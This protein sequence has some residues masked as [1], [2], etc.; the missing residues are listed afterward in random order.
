MDITQGVH[1]SLSDEDIRHI[2]GDNYKN[3]QYSELA[4]YSSLDGLLP[5]LLDYDII[6]YEKSIS[7][8]H[9]V[10]VLRYHNLFEFFGPT[11]YYMI[12]K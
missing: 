1:K 9:W 7:E 8:G 6:L 12:K 2:L 11:D 4:N 3:I 5:N 10:G